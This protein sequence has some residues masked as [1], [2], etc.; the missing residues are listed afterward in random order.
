MASLPE[1]EFIHRDAM[2]DNLASTLKKILITSP[3][4]MNKPFRRRRRNPVSV[5]KKTGPAKVSM[6]LDRIISRFGVASRSVATQWI[7]AG[8][9]RV[10]DKVERNAERWVHIDC[11]RVAVD[12]RALSEARKIYLMLNK[13]A[14]VLTSF[15]DPQARRTVYDYLT[16]LNSWVFPVG[17][18]DKDTSGLLLL[19]NDPDF[20]NRLTD[21]QS[22]VRKHYLAKINAVLTEAEL[23]RLRRGIEIEPG[24]M[25]LPCTVLRTRHTEKFS[26]LEMI[27]TEGKNRQIRRMIEALG[28]TVLKLVRV[29]IG[30][31]PLG[32]LPVGKW[33]LLSR[34]EVR[35]L[36]TSGIRA[37]GRSNRVSRGC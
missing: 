35:Q 20:G 17:R 34:E 8:R 27:L 2:A 1:S 33:R 31:L 7:K 32:D 21:P 30:N 4:S 18:L 14:G 36:Q 37:S 26:W 9:V 16:G 19:T 3:T 28:H 23:E 10:N 29:R 12:G 22:K 25:T 24:V 5:V 6:T 15:G 11:D 13:P